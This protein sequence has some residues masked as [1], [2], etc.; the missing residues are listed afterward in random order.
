MITI[1][2]TKSLEAAMGS[3]ENATYVTVDTEFKRTNTYWPILCLIQIAGPDEAYIIDPLVDGIDLASFYAL[4]A[5]RDVLKVFHASRQ[6]LEIF[7]HENGELPHPV[8]DTQIAAMVC[9]FGDSVGYETLV[10]QLANQQIDKSSRF[11]DWSRRPLSKQQLNYAIGDVTHLRVIYEQLADKL[12]NNGRAEWLREEMDDLEN[13]ATYVTPPEEAWLRLETR[14]NNRRF[15]ALVRAIAAWREETAQ[16]SDIPRNRIMRD[17]LIMELAA[18]PPGN[19]EEMKAV[20]NIPKQAVSPRNGMPNLLNA[21]AAAKKLPQD[22]QPEARKQKK[23]PRGIG[24]TVDLLKVLLKQKCEAEGVAQ[25]LI[26]N[27]ADLELLAADDNA[28]I[29]ALRGWRREVFGSDALELKSGKLALSVRQNK[30]QVT[31][32]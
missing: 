18:H 28:D 8:F 13:P 23:L 3:L 12:G 27:V 25:K 21:I 26:A 2:D 22:Q 1:T 30:I 14:S 24:P 5:N 31:K 16:K 29:A 15:L 20:K 32:L 11:T 4:M 6:D 10:N 17:D 19:V 7:F 9:G